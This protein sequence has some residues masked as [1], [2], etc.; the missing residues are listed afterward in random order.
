LRSRVSGEVRL[1]NKLVA[2]THF[3]SRLFIVTI[4]RCTEANLS[5]KNQLDNKIKC[6][7]YVELM[8]NS[9]DY[10]DC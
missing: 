7:K 6:V 4:F 3:R 10:G 8:L 2:E 5:N 9:L 1:K